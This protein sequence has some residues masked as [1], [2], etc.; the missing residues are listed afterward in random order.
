MSFFFL[1][2]CYC[3]DAWELWIGLGPEFSF[4]GLL[5]CLSGGMGV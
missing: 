2:I 1:I 5:S 3:S 4:K